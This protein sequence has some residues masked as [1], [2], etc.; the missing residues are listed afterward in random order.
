MPTDLTPELVLTTDVADDP[1]I[2]PDG[3]RVVW[4]A[5]PLG[6]DGEGFCASLWIAEVGEPG[7]AK[8][9]TAEGDHRDH[10]PRWSPD[11]SH[12]AFLT[13]R[14]ERGDDALALLPVDG[15]EARVVVAREGRSI[16]SFAWSPDG[17]RIAF[18]AP[19]ER[20]EEEVRREE[21]QD[22]AEVYGEHWPYGRVNLF[23]VST[24]EVAELPT[25]DRHVL[26]A[27][28]SP[29]GE[30]IAFLASPTPELESRGDSGLYLLH[31]DAAEPRLLTM[32]PN[33]GGDLVWL[34]SDDATE[35]LVW[36]AGHDPRP[37][38]GWAIWS[39][40][41]DGDAPRL[42]TTDTDVCEIALR[43]TFDGRDAVV[44][45]AD[46]L[47]YRLRWLD[48]EVVLAEPEADIRAL[49][50]HRRDAGTCIVMVRS[51]A[52]EPWEV[53]SHRDG[54]VE[55]ISN[56]QHAWRE[57]ELASQEAFH[58]T[59]DDGL[60]LD[61]LMIRPPAA[62]GLLPTILLPHGGPYARWAHGF[63][64]SLGNWGQWLAAAGFQVLLPNPRGGMGHGDDFARCVRGEVGQ[65]D[66]RDIIGMVDAAVERGLADPDRLGI[67]GWSQGGY[68]A[69][70]AVT[71][72]DRFKAAIVG[73]GVTDWGMLTMDTDV[74]RF[75]AELGGSRPWDGVGPHRAARNSPISFAGNVTTPVLLLHGKNDARIPP[76]Q[77][78]GFARALREHDVEV[79]QVLY[80]RAP[81]GP[82]ERNHQL[83]LYRRVRTW[84]E[85]LV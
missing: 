51:T 53:W 48:G 4:T 33:V 45:V 78:I 25:G 5:Q 82:R 16:D 58:W 14:D 68:M 81:H 43:R 13:D 39:T 69:A 47:G 77:A 63:A 79:E 11:G 3:R 8:R 2:S 27:V 70:W 52:T 84:F 54:Q 30:A 80:P 83:D 23:D 29:D 19:D 61:G 41:P 22:D 46:G 85:R 7:R 42:E 18:V 66:Y 31:L 40:T 36:S 9:L 49:S 56:H 72:T 34:R 38:C 64:G 37:Q 76:N 1:Q 24:N 6:Y 74:P 65:D 15:G 10:H 59:A 26:E 60:E 35:R 73:A 32:T 62:S 55:R 20:T 50:V 21:E 57:V 12:I 71:Q 67:G 28:W 17:S 44:V 75:E